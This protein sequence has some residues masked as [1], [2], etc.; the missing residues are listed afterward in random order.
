MRTNQAKAIFI[1]LAVTIAAGAIA[2][3]V[4]YNRV[5]HGDDAQNACINNL[6]GIE[7]AKRIVVQ[8]HGFKPG[9]IVTQ[10]DLEPYMEGGWR[11]CPGGGKYTIGPIG[12]NP[13]CSIPGHTLPK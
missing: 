13:T 6:M 11:S 12:T 5:L 9:K 4:L 7:G 3:R 10:G 8:E 1:I 2:A